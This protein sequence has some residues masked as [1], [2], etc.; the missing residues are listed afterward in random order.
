[1]SCLVLVVTVIREAKCW[2]V[3]FCK[4]ASVE[5]HV[6]TKLMKFILILVDCLP[7]QFPKLDGE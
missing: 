6:V 4:V 3:Q 7:S 2:F 5:A 1:M